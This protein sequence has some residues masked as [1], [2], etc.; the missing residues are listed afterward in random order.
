MQLH[1]HTLQTITCSYITETEI[2]SDFAVDN[3]AS[4]NLSCPTHYHIS[5]QIVDYKF[6][7]YAYHNGYVDFFTNLTRVDFQ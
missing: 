1:D 5:H 4:F 2:S 7:K 3:D 6:R